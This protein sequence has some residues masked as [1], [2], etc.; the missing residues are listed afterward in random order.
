M[1][2][3]QTLLHH[4]FSY[5]EFDVGFQTGSNIRKGRIKESMV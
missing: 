3:S 4:Y 5:L 1:S 2:K